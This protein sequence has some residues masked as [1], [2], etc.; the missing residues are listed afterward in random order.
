MVIEAP[1]EKIIGQSVPTRDPLKVNTQHFVLIMYN[2]ADICH[3]DAGSYTIKVDGI[4]VSIDSGGNVKADKN[5]KATVGPV[6]L[7]LTLW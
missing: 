1:V 5:A 7:Q 2:T 6:A 3:L 4:P